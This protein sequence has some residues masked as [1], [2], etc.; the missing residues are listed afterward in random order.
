MRC[1]MEHERAQG[2]QVFDVSEEPRLR[3]HK[4]EISSPAISRSKCEGIGD[5]DGSVLLTPDERR[6]RGP[7]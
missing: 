2:R 1:I 4:H 7:P 6:V 3:H 5:T